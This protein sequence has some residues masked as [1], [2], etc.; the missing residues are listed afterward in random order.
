MSL[1]FMKESIGRP[2]V[3]RMIRA[4]CDKEPDK[5]YCEGAKVL[6]DQR[7]LWLEEECFVCQEKWNLRLNRLPLYT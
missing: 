7:P 3:G 2:R 6:S 1:S 4:H 5:N